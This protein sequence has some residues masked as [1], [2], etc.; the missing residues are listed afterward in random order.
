MTLKIAIKSN[1]YWKGLNKRRGPK[2]VGTMTSFCAYP[3]YVAHLTYKKKG[4]REC[5]MCLFVGP[6]CETKES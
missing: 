5:V 3:A 1:I 2:K 4:V 6:H